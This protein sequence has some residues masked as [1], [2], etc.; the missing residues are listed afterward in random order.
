MDRK[1]NSKTKLY[2]LGK[3]LVS[4]LLLSVDE[5]DLNCDGITNAISDKASAQ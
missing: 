2:L 4:K 1:E 5:D 3:L